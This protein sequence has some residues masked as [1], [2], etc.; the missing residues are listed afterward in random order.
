MAGSFW[1]DF[2]VEPKR[3][4]R[5]IL[6]LGG[7]PSWICKKVSKPSFAVSETEHTFLNNK[8]YYPG[9]VQRNTVTVTLADPVEPDAAATMLKIIQESG[10]QLPVDAEKAQAST[11]SKAKAVQALGTVRIQQIGADGKEIEEWELVNAWIKD[12]K[13]GELDY[14]SDDMVDVEIEIRYDYA[15][16]NKGADRSAPTTGQKG[17]TSGI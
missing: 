8:F 9:P 10:Y 6:Y 4:Y 12:V 15:Q 3:A 16:M 14:E 2:K 13:L 1:S 7:I 11:I 17:D 5:W